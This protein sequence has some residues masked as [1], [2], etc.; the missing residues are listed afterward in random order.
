MSLL[1]LF[2][3]ACGVLGNVCFGVGC[4][5]S[6]WKVWR[7]GKNTELPAQFAWILWTAC[8][9]FYT[10]L[11]GTYGWNWLTGPI[12][13]IETGAYSIV[14]W[15]QY[16]PRPAKFGGWSSE[17]VQRAFEAARA[18]HDEEKYRAE[19]D[20]WA[21]GAP[22]QVCTLPAFHKGP[23][24]GY[25]KSGCPVNFSAWHDSRPNGDGMSF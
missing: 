3:N 7:S 12:G 15:Y 22:A 10:Y 6:A 4:V 16:F 2:L 17:R 25:P 1:S 24:N 5:P 20:K 14:L 21:F 18:K 13:L 23:C 8:T 9:S 19:A 11:L